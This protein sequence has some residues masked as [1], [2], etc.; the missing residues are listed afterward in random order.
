MTSLKQRKVGER[1][2]LFNTDIK[3]QL[4]PSL[5]PSIS[6]PILSLCPSPT[7]THTMNGGNFNKCPITAGVQYTHWPGLV[8]LANS[9][10]VRS[11]LPPSPS[12]P[13]VSRLADCH[14][15]PPPPPQKV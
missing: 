7:H 15:P 1:H 4:L 11:H 8:S 12:H 6:P 9:M 10:C 3:E 2:H 5:T 13:L 14:P